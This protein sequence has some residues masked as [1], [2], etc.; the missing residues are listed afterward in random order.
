MANFHTKYVQPVTDNIGNSV[1]DAAD[2]TKL[3]GR[4]V[5]NTKTPV[6]A[7]RTQMNNNVDPLFNYV[8]GNLTVTHGLQSVFNIDTGVLKGLDCGAIG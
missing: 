4:F 1:D 7:L 5:I 6:E 8:Y 3:A 2:S